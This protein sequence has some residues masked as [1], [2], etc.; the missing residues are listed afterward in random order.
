MGG[1]VGGVGWREALA[2]VGR[3]VGKENTK[4]VACNRCVKG[5]IEC[6]TK[7]TLSQLNK[8]SSVGKMDIQ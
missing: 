7:F 2:Q 3:W 4:M 6:R 5:V 8:D 1:C